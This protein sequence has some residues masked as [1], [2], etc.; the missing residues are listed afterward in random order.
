MKLNV[1][2]AVPKG[3]TDVRIVYDAS[4]FG[5]NRCL[6]APSF[7][8]PSVEAH[9]RSTVETSLMGDLDLGEMFLNFPLSL[10][11][12]PYCEIDLS[13]YVKEAKSWERWE[14]LMMGLKVSPYLAI[15]ATHFAFEVVYGD[16]RDP[17]NVFHWTKVILNLP[18]SPEYEPTQPKVWKY[19]PITQGLV[20]TVVACVDDLQT[21]GLSQSECWQVMHRVAT[22]LTALGIQVAGQKARAPTSKPRPW[23]GMVAWGDETGVCVRATQVKWLKAKV[24]LETLHEEFEQYKAGTIEGLNLK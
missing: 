13:P 20:A 11:L 7:Y 10:A 3:E 2:L 17:L 24:Q 22:I 16:R 1:L 6:W 18:G 9:I 4:Q 21:L 15:E 12:A 5:L 23:V 19:N 14:R 8:L